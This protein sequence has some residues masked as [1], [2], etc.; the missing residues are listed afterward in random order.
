MLYGYFT[1]DE[2]VAAA[3]GVAA[4][5]NMIEAAAAST[6][7]LGTAAVAVAVAVVVVVVVVTGTFSPVVFE[8]QPMSAPPEEDPSDERPRAESATKPRGNQGRECGL[9]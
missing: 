8:N 6:A 7:G 2:A 5:L 9:S 3:S 1:D 4:A